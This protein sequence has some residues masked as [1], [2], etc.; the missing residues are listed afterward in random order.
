MKDNK[1]KKTFKQKV[2]KLVGMASV[3]A[4]LAGVSAGCEAKNVQ[5]PIPDGKPPIV[6]TIENK[7][8][9][10]PTNIA[11][12]EEG[13]VSW[14]KVENAAAY[15]I[16]VN[17][18]KSIVNT[19]SFVNMFDGKHGGFNVS[20]RAIAPV[21]HESDKVVFENSKWSKNAF[22]ERA[23]EE[24]R[25]LSSLHLEIINFVEKATGTK[26]FNDAAW[27]DN[28]YRVFKINLIDSKHVEVVL[29]FEEDGM[30]TLKTFKVTSP[31]DLKTIKDVENC[32][33]N[34]TSLN[35]F[36][37]LEA[38]PNE[39]FDSIF[40]YELY[41]NHKFENEFQKGFNIDDL[42]LGGWRICSNSVFLTKIDGV[43]Y[44][45]K[46]VMVAW[47]NVDG[48]PKLFNIENQLILKDETVQQKDFLKCFNNPLYVNKTT[49]KETK[50]EEISK[51]SLLSKWSYAARDASLHQENGVL[52]KVEADFS[53]AGSHGKVNVFLPKDNFEK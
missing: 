30:R 18:V 2:A 17:G 15:E 8:L 35:K 52:P 33:K 10:A 14:D 16:D 20:V 42:D 47:K 49:C 50:F 19:N 34:L 31:T 41:K 25:E 53:L 22:I 32:F 48:V 11:V 43:G 39:V 7:T 21:A 4:T 3:V 23:N 37:A 27:S 46:N 28:L 5:Q 26:V 36:D 6:D 38:Y 1:E 12:S 13:T 24:R 51:E 40:H 44:E 45:G 9:N 29:P